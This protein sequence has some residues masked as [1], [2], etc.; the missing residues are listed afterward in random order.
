MNLLKLRKTLK[1]NQTELA[2]TLGLTQA[3]YSLYER[4]DRQ[5]GYITIIRLAKIYNVNL[6]WL[7]LDEGDM[8]RN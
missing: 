2:G 7:F 5:M 8:F 3:G 1:L 6:N 4:G